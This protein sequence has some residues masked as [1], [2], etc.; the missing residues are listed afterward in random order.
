MSKINSSILLKL[1]FVTGLKDV[2]MNEISNHPE[3][4]LIKVGQDELYL[5]LVSNL[6]GISKLRSILNVYAVKQN[7]KLNPYYIFKHKTILGELIDV[8]LAESEDVFRTFKI[9]CAG[10][11]SKEVLKIQEFIVNTYKLVYVE[12]ADMEIFIAKSGDLWEVG[13]RLTARPLSLRNYK[14]T[15]IK[16]GLNSTIAFAMNTFC[17]LASMQSYVNIFSGSATLLIEA[18]RSNSKLKFLGFDINKKSNSLAMQN[19]KKA[20]LVKIIHIKTADIFDTPDFGKFDVATADLPFGMQVSKGE[21]LFKLYKCFVDYCE[22]VLN[23]NGVLVAYTSE[24]EILNKILKQSK[25]SVV[26]T[27]TLKIPTSVNARLFTKIFV[28]KLSK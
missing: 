4:R 13:V 24:H 19:I 15:H 8:V 1:S 17:N 28:C 23:T 25:F 18:G 26:K 21:D 3:L 16:G 11:D 9:S 5:D 2:V 14:I 12:D 10:K 27:L 22:N 6:E 20:G 7:A